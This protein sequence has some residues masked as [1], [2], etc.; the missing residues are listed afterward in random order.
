MCIILLGMRDWSIRSSTHRD[1]R[2]IDG[3]RL[4]QPKELSERHRNILRLYALGYTIKE[5]AERIGC[6]QAT[7]SN[8]VN[9]ELGRTHTEVFRRGIDN[10][11]LD[12]AIR[13]RAMA[14]AAL[15]VIE[16]IIQDENA[17]AA[18]RLRAAQDTLD[19]AGYG[20][21][22]RMDIRATSVSL[23]ADDLE[24]IKNNAIHR[25]AKN[26]IDIVDVPAIGSE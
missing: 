15:D 4:Y 23:T 1:G 8:I 16:G 17:P 6:T 25:A 18:L 11:A 20:A 19:R 12:S 14:P 7:V 3:P 22:K 24:E 21:V 2:R 9:S 10:A 26:G 5:I 13:L